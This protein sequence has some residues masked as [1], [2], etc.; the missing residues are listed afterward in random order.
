M[1]MGGDLGGEEVG[2]G[3]KVANGDG[4]EGIGGELEDE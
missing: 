3:G 4:K 1:S 2:T